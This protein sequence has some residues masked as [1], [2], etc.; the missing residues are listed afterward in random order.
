MQAFTRQT[1]PAGALLRQIARRSYSS[2]VN[3]YA[4]TISNLRING[5]TKVLF[6]G[7]TGKQG[8]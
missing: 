6:Q 8:T 5:D 4:A 1:R 2:T 3:P 7:F